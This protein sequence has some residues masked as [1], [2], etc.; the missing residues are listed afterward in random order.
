MARN[1]WTTSRVCLLLDVTA[2][3][4]VGLLVGLLVLDPAMTGPHA[5]PMG[6]GALVA[7]GVALLGLARRYAAPD[8]E[9]A[10]R[11]SLAR[12]GTS[13]SPVASRQGD[14]DAAGRTRPRAPGRAAGRPA[15]PPQ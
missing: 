9:V 8:V 11:L 4:L 2:G 7:L 1:Q 3:M 6:L 12:A 5:A 10:R 13:S 15:Q 14:P